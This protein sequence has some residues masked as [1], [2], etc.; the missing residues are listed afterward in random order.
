MGNKQLNQQSYYI[1]N[2][3]NKLLDILSQNVND[4]SKF[5]ESGWNAACTVL[6]THQL[7]TFSY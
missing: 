4:R 3:P 1:V 5:F 6:N 7:I 2:Q